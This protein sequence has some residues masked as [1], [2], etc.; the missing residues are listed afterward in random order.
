[1]SRVKTI[2]DSADRA[3]E[4]SLKFL[5]SVCQ[6]IQALY[7]AGAE[8]NIYS[9]MF[10][11]LEYFPSTFTK[12]KIDAYVKGVHK[13]IRD[14]D[15]THINYTK[16]DMTLAELKEFAESEAEFSARMK[17]NSPENIGDIM[18]YRGLNKFC[19]PEI[20]ASYT[21]RP[22]SEQVSNSAKKR[23]AKR[24]ATGIAI[25]SVAH[26]KALIAA[27]PDAIRLSAH[28]K[29]SAAPQLGVHLNP[30]HFEGGTPWHSAVVRELSEIDDG[31]VRVVERF[32]KACEARAASYLQATYSDTKSS[33]YVSPAALMAEFRAKSGPFQL[34]IE[35]A[36]KDAALDLYEQV[37]EESG[38]RL[39]ISMVYKP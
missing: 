33:H 18:L 17:D 14:N 26:R 16:L 37:C 32:S 5:N 13:L 6:K 38:K 23:E 8:V 12:A 24:M 4:L 36:D 27:E 3:E 1:M 31:D 25:M 19:L 15:L 11:Y 2:S 7:P 39:P 29:P 35:D 22:A 21:L 30:D 20:E 10:S 9:D 28:A 34:C